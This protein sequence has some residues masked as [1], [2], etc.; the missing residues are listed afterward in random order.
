MKTEIH[1]LSLQQVNSYLIKEEGLILVDAGSPNKGRKFLEEFRKLSVEPENISLILVTHG[2]W[3]HI[4][5]L[6]DLKTATGG[7]VAVNRREK[8]WVEKGLKET[9]PG[10]GLWGKMFGVMMSLYSPL[11]KLSGT[12]VDLVLEDTAF[13]LE[14]YGIHGKA[15]HTPGHSPGSTSLLLDSGEAFVGDLAMNGLPLRLGAGLPRFAEDL[16]VVK[17]SWRLLLDRGAK[18]IY[19]GHG[20]LFKAEVLEKLL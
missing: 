2:H 5:S 8:D 18:W 13:S 16:G 17:K 3:D 6:K 20:K 11:V 1:R 14:S 19:P 7:K 9:P 10:I 4:G 15:I 12:P